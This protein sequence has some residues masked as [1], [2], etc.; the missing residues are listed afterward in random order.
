[1]PRKVVAFAASS[2]IN[3]INKQLVT[4]AASLLNDAQV[5]ILDLNDYEMP[6][7]SVDREAE[8]GH[9]ELAQKFFAL[10]GDCDGVV[11]SLAEHNGN[12]SAAYKNLF[13]WASR[14]DPKVYQNKPVVLLATSPGGRGGKGVLEI[15]LNSMPRY[16][17]E[18]KASLSMP[19]FYDIFDSE[20]DEIADPALRQLLGETV[21]H[22]FD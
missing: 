6:L 18:I 4:Y 5:E 22:L 21:N 17:A 13:D 20:K 3:S 14:I 19:K 1:M 12:Y 2:S 8:L 9:P 15:A 16:A 10:I 11:I 7:F